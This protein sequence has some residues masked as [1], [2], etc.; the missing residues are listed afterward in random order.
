[1]N[2]YFQHIWNQLS[3][4]TVCETDDPSPLFDSL[5]KQIEQAKDNQKLTVF[6]FLTLKNACLEWQHIKKRL[7]EQ[8]AE[9]PGSQTE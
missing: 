4:L 9:T 1:M 6:Q 2:L 3:L 5:I 7:Y 8:N